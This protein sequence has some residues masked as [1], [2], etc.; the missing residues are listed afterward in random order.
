MFEVKKISEEEAVLLLNE[1]EG[2]F[3]EVTQ[4]DYKGETI[5]KKCVA[6]ANSDGGELLIGIQDKKDKNLP[7]GKFERWNGFKDQ[8]EANGAIVDILKNIDPNLTN[9]H[10]EFLEIDRNKELGKVLKVT[11]DKSADVHRTAR[12]NVYIRVGAQCLSVTGDNITNLQ[13]SKGAKSYENQVVADY[14]YNRLLKSSELK[15]FLG[16]YSP[17]TNAKDFLKKQN[18]II[19][20]KENCKSFYAGVLLYDGNPSVSL[21]K[22][23]A[24]KITRYDT[25]EEEPEREN[26]K[27]QKTIE[28]PIHK[29][30]IDGIN[31]I[32]RIINSIPIIGPTGLEKAKY[33]PEAIKETLVNALIHRDY[34]IS[35][36]VSVL[37]FNNRIEVHSPGPLPAH[38]TPEN[39][40]DERFSR[41]A[42]IVRLLNKYPDRPNRDIGEGLNTVFQKM[43][44]VRLKEPIIKNYKTKVIVI[45]PHEPLAS[46]EEQIMQ[47]LDNHSEITNKIARDITGIRS[48]NK[49]KACFYHLKKSGCIEMVPNKKGVRSAWKK[50]DK[51]NTVKEKIQS[52]FGGQINMFG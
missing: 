21:P 22:K 24:L 13:L 49:V 18:L 5:Q 45:L 27:E 2:N 23:C 6:F 50:K 48:E 25:A 30:I 32:Q 51:K 10:L 33:P 47:Y 34:N 52:S 14:N 26:L 19:I 1:D 17:K 16:S 46:P 40:L 4:K 42:K 8:E 28:G 31:E 37:I 38:I 7:G 9:P 41:N 15:I 11:I 35:D 44:E 12:G 43:N 36:D 20:S 39:I 3:F 29:Q